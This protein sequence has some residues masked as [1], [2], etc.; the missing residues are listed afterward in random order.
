MSLKKT[1]STVIGL[2]ALYAKKVKLGVFF[3][4]T[5]ILGLVATSSDILNKAYEFTQNEET[6]NTISKYIDYCNIIKR[7]IPSD[8]IKWSIFVLIILIWV[9][10]L[11]FR[12]IY[13][14]PEHKP[15]KIYHIFGHATLGKTQLKQD[16]EFIEDAKV[17]IEQLDLIEEMEKAK[18][19]LNNLSYVISTQ[20]SFVKKF[21]DKINNTD[22]FGYM[23]I[24]HTP[25]ILRAGYQT[26]D[27]TKFILFHK[28]RN[29]DYFEKLSDKK[30][31]TALNIEKQE[32]KDNCKE[33][34]LAISTTFPIQDNQLYILEPEN[35]SIIKFKTEE[36]GFDV[37]ISQLQIEEYVS[38][39]LKEV[40]R[41][42]SERGITKIHMV[43]SSSV[44]FT[45]ALG[46]AISNHYD[47]QI[48]IYHFDIN[49]EKFYP[50][51]IDISKEYRDCVIIN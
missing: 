10:L 42:V 6:R 9:I 33:L 48:I 19:N 14:E 43:I 23:G 30:T 44:A 1:R 22:N 21:K 12:F 7:L 17:E 36:M 46:Q 2:L 25:L 35:K 20:D 29:S 11:C 28:M 32:I 16:S 24:A 51:G 31:Y 34:I 41:V 26:G 27:E 8:I 15:K 13:R 50:W 37:I 3:L 18:G 5:L 47:P 49:N 40:R 4:I 38:T 45:F 39:I